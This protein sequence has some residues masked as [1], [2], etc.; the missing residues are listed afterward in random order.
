MAQEA[1]SAS[2]TQSHYQENQQ[3]IRRHVWESPHVEQQDVYQSN[4]QHVDTQFDTVTNHEQNSLYSQSDASQFYHDNYYNSNQENHRYTQQIMEPYVYNKE[5]QPSFDYSH[6]QQPNCNRDEVNFNHSLDQR[7]SW[8][9][10]PYDNTSQHSHGHYHHLESQQFQ[11]TVSPH[12][13]QLFHETGY[14]IQQEHAHTD[15]KCEDT[16]KEHNT[17]NANKINASIANHSNQHSHTNGTYDSLNRDHTFSNY[18]Q[19]D[20]TH[21]T[22]SL[23]NRVEYVYCL[24]LDHDRGRYR[25]K[26]NIDKLLP[27]CENTNGDNE[28][29]VNGHEEFIIPRHPYDGFYLRHKT[30]ID[31]R[32]RKICTHEIPP[33]PSPSISP[34]ESPIFFDAV[35]EFVSQE[36]ACSEHDDNVS[37]N[38]N[39]PLG[40]VRIDQ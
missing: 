20:I 28:W 13:S 22:H 5:T 31:A 11:E 10:D 4:V 7:N 3:E 36:D 26:R 6:H 30:T 2:Y 25:R 40:S 35:S 16:N 1:K 34:P 12:D 37:L 23:R 32:G 17:N 33:T 21:F 8:T 14:N 39:T 38:L 29:E 27:I 9:E 24:H 19:T 15:D 18:A